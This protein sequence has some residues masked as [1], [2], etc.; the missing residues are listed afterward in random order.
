MTSYTFNVP[1]VTDVPGYV[2]ELSG[3]PNLRRTRTS[4]TAVMV[5]AEDADAALT[6]AREKWQAENPGNRVIDVGLPARLV[7]YDVTFRR[8][9]DGRKRMT[10]AVRINEAA[11]PRLRGAVSPDEWIAREARHKGKGDWRE[12]A[13]AGEVVAVAVSPIQ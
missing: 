10:V 7:W 2:M 1:L 12:R 11:L 6:A 9:S 13:D 8:R 3:N 4:R 5:T